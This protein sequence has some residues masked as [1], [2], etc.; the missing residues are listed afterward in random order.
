MQTTHG[1]PATPPETK[2][3]LRQHYRRVRAA[4]V[5]ALTPAARTAAEQALAANLTRFLKSALP[6]ASYVAMG[7]ELSPPVLALPRINGKTLSFHTA[8]LTALIPGPFN[9]PAPQITPKLLLIPL[10]AAAPNGARLGQGGGY[11]DRTLAELRSTGPLTLIGI[12]WD[13]QIAPHL[14]SEPHDQNLDW[15]ATPTQLVD[16]HQSR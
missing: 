14:P 12:A 4:Y 1:G 8:S 11:Y 10:L 9:P 15:I 13:I 2:A 3:V 5:A 7:D 6:A 16:C